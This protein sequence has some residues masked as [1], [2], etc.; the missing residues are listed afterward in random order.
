MTLDG[1]PVDD[2]I[3]AKLAAPRHEPADRG[4]LQVADESPERR[5]RMLDRFRRFLKQPRPKLSPEQAKLLPLFRV[6]GRFLFAAIVILALGCFDAIAGVAGGAM[7][8]ALSLSAAV[9]VTGF[10]FWVGVALG[11]R[12][13]WAR[14]A[15]TGLCIA[16]ISA[17]FPVMAW[18][19]LMVVRAFCW[20]FFRFIC[21]IPEGSLF[22]PPPLLIPLA[23]VFVVLGAV[24]IGFCVF[25]IWQCV[26]GVRYLARPRPNGSAARRRVRG[27]APR[28]NRGAGDVWSG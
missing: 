6:S 26:K 24:G 22:I 14:R 13:T 27:K 5:R 11:R 21:G 28:W 3:P 8:A 9:L 17:V 4:H 1:A 10:V 19:W 20:V 18:T 23:L 12:R 15:A 16:A 7:G 2:L 25:V